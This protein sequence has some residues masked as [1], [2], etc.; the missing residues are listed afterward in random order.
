LDIRVPIG[1]LFAGLGVLVGGYGLVTA[2]DA[3]RYAPSLG[4]NINLW[5]G[6]AMLVFGVLLLAAVRRGRGRAAA[7]PADSTVQ[8][9]ETE[10]REHDMGLER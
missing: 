8:G 5:W 2:G 3:A 4:V 7:H 9:Q 10:R 1:G 6:A